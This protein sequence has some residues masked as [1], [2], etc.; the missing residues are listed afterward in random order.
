MSMAEQGVGQLSIPQT[1]MIAESAAL[2]QAAW[3][4]VK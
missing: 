3:N 4:D 1:P 2:V